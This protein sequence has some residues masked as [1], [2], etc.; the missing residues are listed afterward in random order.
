MGRGYL[1]VVLIC[2]GAWLN[3]VPGVAA[4][5]LYRIDQRYGT[6]GF[7]ITSLGMFTTEGRFSRFAGELLLDPEQPQHTHVDVT[8]D[9]NSVEMPL[10]DE[11]TMLRSPNYFDTSRYPTAR[12]V[13]TSIPPSAVFVTRGRE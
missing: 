11:V 4:Q 8:I 5:S 10:D 12:F 7:S 9:G 1:W 6:V 13:S 3:G 2:A